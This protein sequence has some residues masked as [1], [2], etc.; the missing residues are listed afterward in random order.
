VFAVIVSTTSRAGSVPYGPVHVPCHVPEKAVSWAGRPRAG[1]VIVT[2]GDG[3]TPADEHRELPGETCEH[4]AAVTARATAQN[5]PAR[6]L[7]TSSRDGRAPVLPPPHGAY[8]ERFA[9]CRWRSTTVPRRQRQLNGSVDGNVREHGDDASVMEIG[10]VCEVCL[11]R[12][13]RMTD[14]RVM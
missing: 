14:K 5:T 9:L 8:A 3:N 6:S 13:Y 12:T 11:W 1:R 4:A 7:I 10:K 2:G